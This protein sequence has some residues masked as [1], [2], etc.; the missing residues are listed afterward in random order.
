[1]KN[2]LKHINIFQMLHLYILYILI[3]EI[4]KQYLSRFS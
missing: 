1:M 4:K 2:D 3:L